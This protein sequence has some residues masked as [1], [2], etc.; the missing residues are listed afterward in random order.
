M[1]DL[2][3][4]LQ[5]LFLLAPA[6]LA[7]TAPVWGAK[8]K[9]LRSFNTPIDLGLTYKGVRYL[10]DHKTYRGLLLGFLVGG[11]IGLIQTLA[12]NHL[13]FFDSLAHQLQLL[14]NLDSLNWILLGA[15]LGFFALLGDAIKSFFKRRLGIQPG[16]AWP[17]MDQIDYLI[18]AFMIIGIVFNLTPTHY[19]VGL[20][21]Y[22]LI[23]PVISYTAYLLKLKQDRF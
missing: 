22:G 17:V 10:G 9:G 5:M 21:A 18:G 6:G 16:K 23:H 2:E 11:L 14:S 1:F 20:L 15:L 12:I 8:I 3:I 4:L 7:N 19:F 13:A